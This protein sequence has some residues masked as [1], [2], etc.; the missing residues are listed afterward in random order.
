MP[1]FYVSSFWL[2]EGMRQL[3][4]AEIGEIIVSVVPACKFSPTV[5]F[6][7][8]RDLGVLLPCH[9]LCIFL[10]CLQLFWAFILVV[11]LL[12]ALVTLHALGVSVFVQ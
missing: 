5:V 3:V 4:H 11:P 2:F 7:L 10:I 6:P 8:N 12:V 1:I 9:L